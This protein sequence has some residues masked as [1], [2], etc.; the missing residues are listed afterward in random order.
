MNHVMQSMKKSF[1]DTNI[2]VYTLYPVDLHKHK[3]C[4][5]LFEKAQQGNIS[6]WTTEWVIAELV[7]ILGRMKK[8]KTVIKNIIGKIITTKGL[9]MRNGSVFSK[10]LALWIKNINFIDALNLVLCV[11]EEIADGYSYDKGLD[12]IPGFSRLVP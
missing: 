6:L 5:A 4:L 7:W 10:A 9:E 11:E 2:F 8:E 3:R 12:T 1:V